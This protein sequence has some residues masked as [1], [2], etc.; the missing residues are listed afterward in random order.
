[1]DYIK[2]T[3]L[4]ETNKYVSVEISLQEFFVFLGCLFFMA[5]H[6]FDGRREVWWSREPIPAREGAPFCLNNYITR[7]RFKE[8]MRSIRYTSKPQPAYED[9]FHDV[10][11][12]QDAWNLHMETNYSPAWWN[13]LDESMNIFL[14]KYCPGF[15]IVPL[16]PHEEGN[17]YHTICDGDLEKGNPIMWHI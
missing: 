7:N 1:M 16:K 17:E 8:I 6:P 15:M 14:N 9:K 13:C 3:V 5:C 10:R 4:P 11:E 2:N 12:M